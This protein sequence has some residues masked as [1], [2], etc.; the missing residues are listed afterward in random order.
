MRVTIVTDAWSPQIN[1]VARTLERTRNELLSMGHTV[2]IIEPGGFP[3]LPAMFEPRQRLALVRP[4][5]LLR[6]FEAQAPEA[7]HIA[8][9][10]P[11]GWAARSA[12]MHAGLSFTTAFHTRFPDYARMRLGIPASFTWQLLRRF[13]EPARHTMVP[14]RSIKS[15]L[16]AQGFDHVELW[17]RGVDTERFQPGHSSALAGLARPIHLAVGRV[18]REKNLEAFLSLELPGS[19]VVVGDGPMLNALR[20]RHPDAYFVGAVEHQ[21]LAAYYR[22]AD[23][24]VFPSLTDTFGLVILEA[25]ACGLPVAAFPV[26]GPRDI[27][28]D[29]EG[30][31]LDEDL[32]AACLRAATMSRHAVRRYA[33]RFTWR[34]A[35]E[36]F[37]SLLAVPAWGSA[38]SGE[39]DPALSRSALS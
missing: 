4:R 28:Q 30:G 9:E 25:M 13:H 23:V 27:L 10:G 3:R 37:A 6:L 5:R 29:G 19:K 17:S 22:G 16:E 24:L 36:R 1:G 32:R 26:A 15:L 20:R 2:S 31:V 8:T 7:L 14:T 18:S 34:A 21:A 35:T 33:E 39:Q 38:A 12:A 11:L